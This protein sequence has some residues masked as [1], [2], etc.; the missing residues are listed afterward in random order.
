MSEGVTVPTTT[1]VASFFKRLETMEHIIRIILSQAPISAVFTFRGQPEKKVVLDFTSYPARVLIDE[2][3][4]A[5]DIYV[6]VEGELMH[7]VLLGRMNPGVAAGRREML[8]RGSPNDLAR[9]IPMFDFG[10]VL[11]AEHLADVGYNGFT[12]RSG[13]TPLKEA[14]MSGQVFKGDPIPLRTLSTFEKVLF[15]CINS[16]SYLLGYGVGIMRYRILEKLSLFE[17][18]ASMSRGLAAAM[19][20]KKEP[21]ALPAKD[22][23]DH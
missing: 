5:G 4:R 23:T 11:Y 9:F 21:A 15:R 7:N 19:S 20:K 6:T 2:Q 3:K 18:L 10:P 14:V 17:V 12:R 16:A 22:G 1:L 8:L 13:E